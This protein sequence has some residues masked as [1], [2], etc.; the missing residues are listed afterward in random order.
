MDGTADEYNLRVTLRHSRRQQFITHTAAIELLPVVR[1]LSRGVTR[2]GQDFGRVQLVAH[3]EEVARHSVLVIIGPHPAGE[4][5]LF[6][7][8]NAGDSVGPG[9][10]FREWIGFRGHTGSRGCGGTLRL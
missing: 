4:A 3:G 5:N 8:V 10:G 7:V 9:F 6:D 2:A 1:L